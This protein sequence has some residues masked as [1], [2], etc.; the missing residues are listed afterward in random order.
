MAV[1]S[2]RLKAAEVNDELTKL[3]QRDIGALAPVRVFVRQLET[4]QPRQHVLLQPFG[5][6]GRSP[7]C[8]IRL[9]NPSVSFR[10]AYLQMIGGRL[11]CADLGSRLGTHWGDELQRSGWLNADEGIR[12]GPYQ[13]QADDEHS[14]SEAPRFPATGAFDPLAIYD[15]HLGELPEVHLEFL[16][17][18]ENLDWPVRRMLTFAGSAR[19]C[20]LRFESE[21]IS[22]V[23]CSLLLTPNGLWVI[24][25]LGRGGTKINGALIRNDRLND[26]DVLKV[27]QFQMRARYGNKTR[28]RPTRNGSLQKD[29]PNTSVET[30]SSVDGEPRPESPHGFLIAD[31]PD[32]IINPAAIGLSACR[33][34]IDEIVV[35]R[36]LTRE[37]IDTVLEQWG[38]VAPTVDELSEAL[39]ARKLLSPWQADQLA[40]EGHG[41]LVL[42]NRYKLID[43]LGYGS[44][45][46]VY[47]TFDEALQCEVALKIPHHSLRK[48]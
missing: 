6:I 8:D 16:N 42:E 24:D 43:R 40:T 27:G 34:F 9:K 35:N 19:G 32:I 48:N 23:H 30:G 44:M 22:R 11:F 18:P 14:Q 31:L 1:Y 26:G 41:P 37:Q 20:K 10:H 17:A 25:L 46:I 7:N 2:F 47:R 12:I 39:I 5:V 3:F 29:A 28:S 33:R 38:E 15:G 45:G 13:I 36:L 4:S 21:R